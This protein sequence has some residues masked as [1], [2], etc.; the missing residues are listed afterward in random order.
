VSA[1]SQLAFGNNSV[2][3]NNASEE[4]AARAVAAGTSISWAAT[5]SA[6]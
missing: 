6:L 5:S 1:E 4:D 2:L 3:A